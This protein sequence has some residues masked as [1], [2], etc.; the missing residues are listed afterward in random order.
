[1]AE[2]GVDVQ[3]HTHTHASPRTKTDFVQEIAVNRE[4][5]TRLTAAGRA[6][7]RS[8]S[9]I[10]WASIVRLR[11]LARRIAR[12]IGDDVRSGPGDAEVEPAAAA[13]V[14]GLDRAR[15]RSSSKGGFRARRRSWR[16]PGVTPVPEDRDARRDAGGLPRRART[17][18]RSRA[19][20]GRVPRR[21]A[22]AAGQP[23]P[24]A[25]RPHVRRG[26]SH[27]SPL[28]R[29]R[30]RAKDPRSRTAPSSAF[31]SCR[32]RT[33]RSTVWRLCRSTKG[34]EDLF[35]QNFRMYAMAPAKL[36]EPFDIARASF[37]A[38]ARS[39]A[40]ALSRGTA[41]LG[42]VRH[43]A[44]VAGEGAVPRASAP[45]LVAPVRAAR[46][47]ARVL[48]PHQPEPAQPGDPAGAR[49]A[50]LVSPHGPIDGTATGDQGT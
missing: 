42:S 20:L 36:P 45:R 41:R 31:S 4:I 5:I 27:A 26:H 16:G 6:R 2:L 1:M 46:F 34:R 13:A 30:W 7:C 23:R 11:R 39:R 14:R 44:V 33:T 38:M 48:Q 22:R 43:P 40:D 37:V 28:S 21:P 19:A 32:W 10:R 17:R 49:V 8:I 24:A 3:L 9:A 47:S 35:C 15:R 12:V 29:T 18:S 25:V 50:A